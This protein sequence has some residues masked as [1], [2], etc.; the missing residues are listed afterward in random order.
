MLDAARSHVL[1]IDFQAR[2]MPA[3]HEG[4]GIAARAGRLLGAARLMDVPRTYTEQIPEKLGH[5]VPDLA[6]RPGEAVLAKSRF[7][8][9][10]ETGLAARVAAGHTLVVA[11]CEAHV[12]VLQTV[13]GLLEAGREVA[14][15]TDAIGSRAPADREAALARM[16]RAGAVL[17][18]TEMAVF[19]WLGGADHPRFREVIALIK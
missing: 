13:L 17:V 7:D 19:E 9:G 1:L 18:T 5:T 6:P 8:A 4:A 10:P 15:V 16:A 3:I 12:C 11:G 2:L 14:V